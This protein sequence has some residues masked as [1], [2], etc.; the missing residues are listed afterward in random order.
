MGN[1]GLCCC[2]VTSSKCQLTALFALS[3]TTS[4]SKTVAL[5]F[6]W[7]IHAPAKWL[8]VIWSKLSKIRRLQSEFP[9]FSLRELVETILVFFRWLH[10]YR[11][12]QQRSPR[13][14]RN[15]TRDLHFSSGG[16]LSC[17]LLLF[18]SPL[19]RVRFD[20]VL[21]ILWTYLCRVISFLMDL[22]FLV[23]LVYWCFVCEWVRVCVCVCVCK[24]VC[25]CVCVC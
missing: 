14:S 17:V 15:R 18:C 20:W 7:E 4:V 22:V 25:V 24:S 1:S 8:V 3:F 11:M 5:F 19:F 13:I 9:F 16:K 10:L 23:W 21:C 12:V 2:L 6:I